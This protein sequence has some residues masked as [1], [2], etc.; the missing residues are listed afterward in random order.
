MKVFLALAQISIPLPFTPV[1]I[2]GQT[3]GVALISL[4]WGW[5]LGAGS[6]GLYLL[7]G[8]TGAPIFAQGSHGLNIGPT[9]GYLAGLFCASIVMGTLADC[10]WTLKFRS[11]WFPAFLG[12][13]VVFSCGLLVLSFYVPKEAL[14]RSGLWPFI[15]G[16]I[17]KTLLVA[18]IVSGVS[19][20]ASSQVHR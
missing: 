1:P 11:A 8:F 10:G 14:L 9:S 18:K 3:F 15:P 4:L 17:I 5:K 13:C 16:D 6:V 12:S 20:M 7:A 2:T 19:S